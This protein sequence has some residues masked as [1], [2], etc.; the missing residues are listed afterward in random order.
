M[1]DKTGLF[2][3][4]TGSCIQ[5]LTNLFKNNKRLAEGV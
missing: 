2:G 3:F 4:L 5:T 1:R